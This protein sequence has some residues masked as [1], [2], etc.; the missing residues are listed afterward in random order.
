VPVDLGALVRRSAQ[1]EVCEVAGLGPVAASAVRDRLATGDPFLAAVVTRGQAVVGVAHGGPRPRRRPQT[2]L[3]WLYP[4]GAAQGC[5]SA[6]R[7]QL[8]H[9]IEWAITHISV[10]DRLDR[11]CPHHHGPKTREGWALV[12]GRGT[13]P[14]VPPDDPRHPRHARAQAPAHGPPTTEEAA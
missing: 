3:A 6:A 14:F 11:L 9:R 1:G 4:T 10:F 2:A 5:G 7:L 13:R 8:D 12:A